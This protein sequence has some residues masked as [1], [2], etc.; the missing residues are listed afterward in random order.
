MRPI[1]LYNLLNTKKAAS[2]MYSACGLLIFIKF[3]AF[4]IT[5]SRVWFLPSSFSSLKPQRFCPC[6]HPRVQ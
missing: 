6:G 4:S 2:G 3:Y 1:L 5:L